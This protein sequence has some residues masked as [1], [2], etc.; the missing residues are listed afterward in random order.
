M[1]LWSLA[2][3][4]FAGPDEPVQVI[5]AYAVDHGQLLGQLDS[6]PGQ[7]EFGLVHVPGFYSVDRAIPACFDH[8]SDIPASCAPPPTTA[9]YHPAGDTAP[10]C[11]VAFIYNA[12]YPPLYY[13]IVGLVGFIS[14]STTVLYLMRALS[15]LIAAAFLALAVMCV[16]CYSSRPLMILGFAAA[17]TPMLIYLGGIVNPASLEITAAFSTWSIASILAVDK[18]CTHRRS[19]IV[20][21]GLSASVMALARPISPF[22]LALIAVFVIFSADKSIL[23]GLLKRRDFQIMAAVIFFFALIATVWI[24]KEHATDVL[25]LTKIA[26]DTPFIHVLEQSFRHNVYYIPTMIGIFGAFD[27]YSPALTYV[28]YYAMIT[29]LF[30]LA[31]IVSGKKERFILF[32][33]VALILLIPVAISSSQAYRYGYTWNGK[34]TLPFAVGLPILSGMIFIKNFLGKNNRLTAGKSKALTG[35]PSLATELVPL[36]LSEAQDTGAGDSPALNGANTSFRF[37]Q[38]ALYKLIYAFFIMAAV[39]Q[40]LAFYEAIRRYSVGIGGPVF[41]F[42]WK[43]PWDAPG[44]NATLVGLDFVLMCI[45][46]VVGRVM[47]QKSMPLDTYSDDPG[48]K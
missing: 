46:I 36:N 37:S 27:T 45:F 21:L 11:G 15:A 31:F 34:D 26:K 17:I 16:L 25:S 35:D 3:P 40:F 28:L 18:D 43:S 47:I 19:L 7:A 38:A 10:P 48:A 23:L 22:W 42:L 8:K 33:L 6:Q 30:V 14:P 29:L 1:E 12:R 39:G 24:L 5:K 4:L 9:C 44:G 2:T 32:S 20:Y 13:S 41:A